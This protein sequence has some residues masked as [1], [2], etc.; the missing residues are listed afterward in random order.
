MTYRP[1]HLTAVAA[2][3]AAPAAMTH[4]R[5]HSTGPHEGTWPS[6]QRA[7]T[8]AANRSRCVRRSSRTNQNASRMKKV[9]KLSSRATRL[10]TMASPSIAISSD[11][12]V[13]NATDPV[14]ALATKYSTS[15]VAVPTRAV[16]MRQPNDESGPNS[17]MPAPIRNF[18]SG[19]C[20]TKLPVEVNTSV[21]PARKLSFAP[22]GQVAAYPRSHCVHASLT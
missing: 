20:T 9:R 13:A 22:S 2:P 1:D 11:A 6:L 19:G 7:A 10:R 12:T 21:S 17:A 16:A 14:I 3:A 15:T 18:P 5:F 8:R 4:G